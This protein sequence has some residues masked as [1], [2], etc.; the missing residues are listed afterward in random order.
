MPA[1]D[2]VTAA[3]DAL[4]KQRILVIDGAMGTMIQS[5][6][7]AESDFRGER[8]KGH[9]GDLKN[10]ADLLSLTRP[11][12]IEQI[13]TAYLEAGADVVETNTFNANAVSLADYGLESAVYELNVAAARLARSAAAAA[14]ARDPRR[15]RFVAGSLGPT[16]RSASMSRDASDPGARR[17][18]F[19]Q[20]VD[21][22]HEQARGL[23]DGGVDLLL[24]ETAFDVLNLKAAL[25][26]IMKLFDEGARRVPVIASLTFVPAGAERTLTGQTVEAAWNSIS[27]APLLAVGL[28]C[29]LPSEMRPRLE[30]LR[31]VAPVYVSAHPNAGLPDARLPTRFPETP[32]DM[33]RALGEWARAGLVNLVGGCCGTTPEHVRAIAAAVAGVAPRRVPRVW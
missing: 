23:L 3:L 12:L 18:T 25:F 31:A 16:N 20:L 32:E 10:L 27:H 30:E 11:D 13:H 26:A 19:G 22:Y 33:A 24:P 2:R 28:N 17:V 15:P 9:P 5:Y 8:F 7:L 4:L 29:S 21:A 6:E 1:A 14:G